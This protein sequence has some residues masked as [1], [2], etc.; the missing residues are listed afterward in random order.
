[1]TNKN[2]RLSWQ[3]YFLTI[4]NAVSKRSTCLRRHYGAIIVK[5][6]R[7]ISSGYNG[8]ARG[9][10]NCCDDGFCIRERMGVQHEE[11]YDLCRAIHS[12]QNAIINADPK[13]MVG[14]D[15]YIYGEDGDGNIVDSA[16]CYMCKRM[17]A[18]ARLRRVIYATPTN[19]VTYLV[20]PD[21]DRMY[22]K[23][24]I[25]I[26]EGDKSIDRYMTT[27]EAVSER[28]ALTKINEYIVGHSKAMNDYLKNT[29]GTIDVP[30]LLR[31]VVELSRQ[32][33]ENTPS[34]I[35]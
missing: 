1:M 28:E 16:P 8:A 30:V 21:M 4:A 23:V 7:I 22:Y 6:K 2:T 26:G 3:E 19:V 25:H 10:S 27:D 13:E 14:A 5:D 12:E 18:N 24:Q 33:Y 11:R 17:I 9:E 34:W 32:E 35:L 15:I 31:N 20:R 29:F